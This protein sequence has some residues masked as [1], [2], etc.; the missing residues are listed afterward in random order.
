MKSENGS[1]CNSNKTH[2]Q[3]VFE[4]DIQI[5]G[6]NVVHHDKVAHCALARLHGVKAQ[7]TRQER[8]AIHAQMLV[9]EAQNLLQKVCLVRKHCLEHV[10]H[11]PGKVEERLALRNGA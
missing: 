1:A 4:I 10:L 9:V 6:E 5:V 8:V 3:V 2:L 7:E 11:V